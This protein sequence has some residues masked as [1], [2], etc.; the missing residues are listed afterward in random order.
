MSGWIPTLQLNDGN[1]IPLLGYG[2]GTAWYKTADE[3]ALDH[4][5]TE[6]TKVALKLG[7][8]HQDGAEA[9]KTERE[10]GTALKYS[11]IK[12]ENLFITTK[13]MQNITDILAALNA[14]LKKLGLEY[15]DL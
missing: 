14:S 9:Y 12:R 11:G 15:V 13:V 7:Y 1:H 6:A 2:T 3:D 5:C 8:Y 10:L 4:A